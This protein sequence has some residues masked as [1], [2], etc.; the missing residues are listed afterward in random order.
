MGHFIA[1]AGPA[2][3][4]KSTLARELAH[5]L[6]APHLDLDAVTADLMASAIA[7]A[8][9]GDPGISQH[10]VL[11]RIRDTRYAA[12]RDAVVA[13]FDEGRTD[14]IASAPFTAEAHDP[15]AWAAWVDALPP[16]TAP[17]LAWLELDP[18]ERLRRMASRGS[19]RDTHLIEAGEAPAVPPPT[20]PA[21]RLDARLPA[22]RLARQVLRALGVSGDR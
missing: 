7:D 20:V 10:T 21:L 16:G 6:G 12:L 2:G 3:T 14:V 13:A 9:A 22:P 4:G 8:A 5:A 11:S 18:A 1:V 19:A 17:L 15:D